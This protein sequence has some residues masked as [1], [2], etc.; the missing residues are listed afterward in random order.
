M[1]FQRPTAASCYLCLVNQVTPISWA[2]QASP[3]TFLQTLSSQAH[4]PGAPLLLQTS[5]PECEQ[6]PVPARPCA[7]PWAP[8]GLCFL[9]PTQPWVSTVLPP[10][11][12]AGLSRKQ[13]NSHANMNPNVLF[14]REVQHLTSQLLWVLSPHKRRGGLVKVRNRPPANSCLP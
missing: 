7:E 13:T 11:M 8:Y 6:P 14:L 4:L 1:V 9:F 5:C 2:G 10:S 3:E 12:P